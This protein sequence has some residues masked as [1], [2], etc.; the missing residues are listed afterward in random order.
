MLLTL[1][2]TYSNSKPISCSEHLT[3]Q[4][5]INVWNFYDTSSPVYTLVGEG[6][7]T[8]MCVLNQENFRNIIICGTLDGGINT[9]DITN[10]RSEKSSRMERKKEAD[11]KECRMSFSACYRSTFMKESLTF[12][13]SSIVDLLPLEQEN[14]STCMILSIDRAG[15]IIMW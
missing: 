7:F 12:H 3:N 6:I 15:Q 9:W 11:Q 10:K 5:L 13:Q 4:S 2:T 1:H 14:S 8:V